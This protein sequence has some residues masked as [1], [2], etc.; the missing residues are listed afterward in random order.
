M[1][2]LLLYLC[3]TLSV[4]LHAQSMSTPYYFRNFDKDKG[5]SDNS[6]NTILQDHYGMM[7]FGTKDGLNLYNGISCRTF[8]KENSALG[9]NFI[10]S[11][12]ED[13]DGFIWIGTDGGVYIYSPELEQFTFLDDKVVE[14]GE[15]IV[16]NIPV[17]TDDKNGNIWISSH[18]QG[19]FRYN[20]K[21]KELHKQNIQCEG[22]TLTA[23]VSQLWFETHSA[24]TRM[25]VALYEDD[26][27][28][29]DNT[30]KGEFKPYQ[31]KD[32]QHPFEGK[33]I[34]CRLEGTHNRCLI[35]TN[36]GLI[37]INHTSETSTQ[38]L[39]EYVRAC[40][41][42]E[43]GQLWVGTEKGIFIIN[44]TTH[45]IQH[46][47]ATHF[48]D[49]F[50][51]SDNAVYAIYRDRENGMWLGSYFGGINYY[52]NQNSVFRKIYPN[53]S[54]PAFGKRIREL[55]T[56]PDGMLWIGTEDRGLFEYNPNTHTLQPIAH[57]DL[58]H[59]IHGLC[60]I[61][62][63]MW[64]GSFSG[65]L[66]RINIHTKQL[67][68]YPQG[69]GP[70]H[71]PTR[72][73]FTIC[74]TMAGDTFLGTIGGVYQYN[75]ANDSFELL[76]DMRGE[77]VYYLMED[78]NANLWIATYSNGVY[79]YD[80]QAHKLQHIVNEEGNTNSLPYDK[81][82]S[83]MED[84]HNRIWI[85]TQGG[86]CCC[87]DPHSKQFKRYGTNEGFPSNVVLRVVEDKQG[88][89][90]FTTNNGLVSLNTDNNEMH[91]Y[92]TANGLLSNQFN[93]Q[94]GTVG[95][96]GE[97]YLGTIEGLVS[98]NPRN[99]KKGNLVPQL[100]VS[101]L[102][103]FNDRAAIGDNGAPLER[104]ILYSNDVDLNVNQNN[105]SL[106]AAVLSFQSPE[107]NEIQYRL[108]DYDRD[109]QTL[110][111][112][113]LIRYA[114]LP[115]G[116][117]H[118]HIKGKSHNGM[119]TEERIINLYIHP[120]FYLTI[121]AYIIYALLIIAIVYIIYKNMHSRTLRK[122][123][124]AMEKL[125]QEKEHELYDAKIEFFTN[126]AHEIR[127]PLTLIKSPLEN[128][129]ASPDVT[130][131]MRDDL[132]VM[133][134]NTDRLLGLVNQ[135]LD[136]RK[137]ESKGFQMH[138]H[139]CDLADLLRRT[140]TRFLPFARQRK[141]SFTLDCPDSLIAS[142]DTE[143][144]TKIVSNL[145]TNAIKYS[146]TFVRV[147]LS[148]TESNV[149]LKVWNDGNV[150]PQNQREAIFKSFSRYNDN[151]AQTAIGSGI[152]LTL[153]RSLAEL[154]EG[155]LVMDDDPTCNRFILNLPT[156]HEET[157][158]QAPITEQ[159]VTTTHDELQKP[160]EQ[161][162][163]TLLVVEDN[164]EMQEFIRRQL[165]SRYRVLTANDGA[166]ALEV[167]NK[168]VIHLIVSDVMMPVMDGMELCNHVKNDLNYSHI[169]II[170]L[171]AKVGVQS[172]IEALQQGADAYIEKPFSTE[173]LKASID[174]LLHSR[175]K[176][177]A[178][179]RNS[180]IAQTNIVAI[181]K[182][183]EEFLR[184]LHQVILDNMKDSDFSIDQL[185]SELAMSRSSLNRKIKALLDV[186]PN[187]YVRLERLKYA[188]E[189]LQSGEYKINE[190]CYMAGFNTPSYF[191][192]CFQKQ[193]GVLPNE[194]VK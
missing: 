24:G 18:E 160:G 53:E 21:N 178:T 144:F 172:T 75:P 150:V 72:H 122:H 149:T 183:D 41:I 142:V 128:V 166:Q 115:Y 181:S 76:D 97:I 174:N 49:R 111:G 163:Y 45:A 180:P 155:S 119:E 15:T 71:L 133:T 60:L 109:W 79:F 46:I 78:H 57:P 193:F 90:W 153:A 121:W 129:L 173:H 177:K 34:N 126:V 42:G 48:E 187:D 37:E 50:S 74:H 8:R 165:I 7:W 94:S 28:Y 120:P 146:S 132:E 192:K 117:Y 185:A 68:H 137:T 116:T 29:T 54:T 56:T 35:G 84:S 36:H 157:E 151:G 113:D 58:Y 17:I 19:V 77:F 141:L 51:L 170:L 169:P 69:N 175:E 176:L 61:D 124:H 112:T 38:L 152:G 179:Y 59:N 161:S 87:Y 148:A 83:I 136:F 114:N 139:K 103:I 167:L 123:E 99:F 86:G 66:S 26:L 85:A 25:W 12:Y 67:R 143:G 102:Y 65:G 80:I 82:V 55:H 131:G 158:S 190:V 9:N 5:L 194:F 184:H 16:H 93:Y 39:N 4:V 14:T 189:L 100:V 154:H 125:R 6:V 64:V 33:E 147:E 63:E 118:L 44:T 91:I 108:D 47:S 101:D 127:T 22:R 164:Q 2:N 145:F 95:A 30:E 11:L 188:A 140:H 32:G 1:R 138:F 73:V 40:C 134:L 186:S 70:G 89:L 27:Y 81:V 88:L 20:K 168:E 182:A 110:S 191:A 156:E 98:F 171:T 105:I 107:M 10:T 62:N 92:S 52:S 130:P 135:L 23:N 3:L 13:A 159:E 31:T 162:P 43:D 106:R 104:S 96:D